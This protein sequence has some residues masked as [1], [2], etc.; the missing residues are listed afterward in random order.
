[1]T[2]PRS[3]A[4]PDAPTLLELDRARWEAVLDT[5]RDAIVSID[6]AGI[7]TLFNRTAEA[8]F[9]YSADE[10]LGRKVSMLMPSPYREGH[11]QYMENYRTTGVPKAIGRIRHVFTHFTLELD[12]V[13]RDHPEGDG[14]WHPLD[15][16]DEAGLPTLY[17]KAVDLALAR[18]NAR[19]AA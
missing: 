11:D 16:L 9:G 4:S 18:P 10:V 19:R 1:M 15:R 5:A 8:M 17:R 3:K 12:L 14:W 2:E 13:R 6:A 7:V